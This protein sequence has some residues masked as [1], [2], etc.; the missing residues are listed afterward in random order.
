MTN[1]KSSAPTQ[2]DIPAM[3]A[4][5]VRLSRLLQVEEVDLKALASLVES[6]M[7]LAA[8]VMKAVSSAVTG[9]RGRV[10]SVQQ[11]LTFLGIREVAAIT[12]EVSMRAAFP[13]I[14]ELDLV[15][16]R[17]ARRGTLM[18]FLA[19]KMRLEPYAAHAA[20]LFEECGKAV[21]F[22]HAPD[23][24]RSM[25]RAA[26]DDTDLAIL[27]RAGFGLGHD[28]LGARLCEAW[29]LSPEAVN[30]VRRH[31]EVLRT[32][33]LPAAPEPRELSAVSAIVWTI[34]NNPGKLGEA[35]QQYA[36]QIGRDPDDVMDAAEVAIERAD[37]AG[38][39]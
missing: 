27:E 38:A 1:L 29:M 28:E 5:L 34:M 37:D 32:G 33:Q 21:L 3:P 15:W 14:V 17:G 12:Y 36:P 31:L 7:A 9:V 4:A 30:C 23:H 13:P 16:K 8:A 11:A 19:Q 2:L 39:G 25:L 24:Y 22:R 10:N 18:K 6:D 26:P 35:V 20:G